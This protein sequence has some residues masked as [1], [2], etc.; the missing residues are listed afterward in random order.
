MY[1]ARCAC[2]YEAHDLLEGCGMS[3]PQSE[4]LLARCNDCREILSIRARRRRAGCPRCGGELETVA[5]PAEPLLDPP[6][7]EQPAKLACPR[8]GERE[9]ELIGVGDWD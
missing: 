8:C 6:T 3:G 5:I 1:E 2:G 7:I 9:L 4:L